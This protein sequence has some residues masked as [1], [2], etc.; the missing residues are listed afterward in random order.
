MTRILLTGAGGQVGWEL[1]RCAPPDF[2]IHA[3]SRQALDVTDASAVN[4]AVATLK[5]HWIVN[6]AAYTAVDGAE[7]HPEAAH[8]INALG[9]GNIARAAVEQGARLLHLSTDFIF[10][11]QKNRPYDPQDPAHPQCVYGQTKLEGEQFVLGELGEQALIIRTAWVYSVHGHNFVKTMLR[12]MQER[13]QIGVVEDQV[14]SPTWAAGLAQV[15]CQSIR[16]ELSGIYHWSDAGVA[17]WYDFAMAIWEIGQELGLVSTP[18]TVQPIA[19]A[20]YPT[21]A[22]RPAFSVLCKQSLRQALGYQGDHWRVALQKM[23]KELN[24]V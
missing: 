9:A 13:E 15:I 23:L 20:D 14:G 19:T 3:Y 6:S 18:V 4:D 17:S 7:A 2:E 10:D 8:A 24:D 12:L 16:Q 22:V 5:P 1:Q 11:G 21:A